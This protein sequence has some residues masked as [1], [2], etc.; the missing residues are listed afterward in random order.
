MDWQYTLVELYEFVCT[1][2]QEGLWAY[3]QRFSNNDQP[4]FTDQEIVTIY[5]FA[6]LRGQMTVK[7]IHHYSRD[8][9]QD[10]FPKLPTYQSFNDRLN[11]L[12]AVFQ[13]L[14]EPILDQGTAEIAG[15][16]G[17]VKLLDSL[18]VV[19]AQR[20]R[21]DTARVA[22]ELA[23]KG[24]CSSKK[25]HYYGVKLH[26]LAQRR[27]GTIPFPEGLGLSPAAAHDLTVAR[28]WLGGL[29]NCQVYADKIYS[30]GALKEQLLRVQQV[31]LHTPVKRKKGQRWLYYEDRLYS[32]AV[33]RVR[34][35]IESL[36]NWI[37]EQTG[38][39]LA[40]KVR[41]AKGLLVH[42][43]GKLAA[44]MYKLVFKP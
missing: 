36:F 12:G 13:A 8:H 24:Y 23:N 6:T 19:L 1:R 35:P 10:W 34:Q 5:L 33:S 16:A 43:F 21:S 2:F 30:D 17:Q 41:S 27:P 20:S 22:P 11:R 44:A 31:E 40:S 18:P 42:V 29:H 26:V 7:A 3:C 9:L 39:E 37:Q 4:P 25:L 38:I 28:P 32:E 15:T 14:I